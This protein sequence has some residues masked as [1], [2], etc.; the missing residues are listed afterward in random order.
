MPLDLSALSSRWNE[1]LLHNAYP[2]RGIVL[3][4]NSLDQWVQVYWIMGRS[5]NSRNRVFTV[6]NQILQTQAA[7]PSQVEHPS[8]ILYNAMKEIDR[9]FIVTNGMQ[10]D[11]LCEWMS[12][13]KS[14]ETILLTQAHEPDAPNFTPRISACIDLRQPREKLVISIIK[15]NPFDSNHSE[16]HFF[17][18]QTVRAG[19]G[20]AITTY[21]QDGNPL[22]AF[23][24]SPFLVTLKGD[25]EQIADTFWQALNP[26]NRVSLAVKTIDPGEK[27]SAIWIINKYHFK[28]SG[29]L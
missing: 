9:C 7:D 12:R 8:L 17:Y 4:K 23:E 6:K 28:I 20:Y 21:Q 1:R 3:G 18:Y 25:A 19:Y 11:L 24:G 14:F 10:T 22:P 26:D 16:H 13:G 5:A 27:K 29:A 2:G 15:A